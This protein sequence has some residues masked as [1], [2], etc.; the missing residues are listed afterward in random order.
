M[1]EYTALPGVMRY[2]FSGQ[3]LYW[4]CRSRSVA[5]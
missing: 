3:D 2:I 4:V 5:L 1:S